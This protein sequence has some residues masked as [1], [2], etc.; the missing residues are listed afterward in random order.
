MQ[1]ESFRFVIFNSLR[2]VPNSEVEHKKIIH[3]VFI[4]LFFDFSSLARRG[5][6]GFAR[7]SLGTPKSKMTRR[8]Y[9]L[10]W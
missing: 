6:W 10:P 3:Y 9:L 8:A 2:R 7:A 1:S 4:V 5:F